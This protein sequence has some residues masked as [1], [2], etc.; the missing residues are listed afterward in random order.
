MA[1]ILTDVQEVTPAWLNDCLAR[2]LN[3]GPNRVVEIHVI[4]TR[5]TRISS[6]YFLHIIYATPD[7]A[8]PD[9]FFLKLPV[10]GQSLDREEIEFYNVLVP[11][12]A[13]AF[14]G[15]I[16]PFVACF[17]AAYSASPE[18][19]H[20]LLADMSTTHFTNQA[21]LPPSR[22]LCDGVI[23]AYARFHAFW[24]GHPGLGKQ[25]GRLLTDAAVDNF[26]QIAQAKLLALREV[27]GDAMT[28]HQLATLAAVAGGWPTRRRA[29]VVAG[30]GITIVH[31]DPHP[32][33]FLYPADPAVD[34]VKLIDWQSWRVDTGT[35]DL[36]YM[37]AC[38][39][40]L[41]EHDGLEQAMLVR[42]LHGLEA[43]G[44]GDYRWDDL[45]YDYRASI[46]RCLFF[47]LISWSPAKWTEGI[48]WRERVARGLDA[49]ARFDCGELLV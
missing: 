16:S 8:L 42:Y 29:R 3:L 39:W 18:G 46:I 15:A 21:Q 2:T 44:V 31:R 43:A 20:L 27:V 40:P 19:S 38:H 13:N 24:W 17:D 47:L 32:L 5:K 14:S 45:I 48:G 35:D 41:S 1:T 6:A 26:I 22:E 37:M 25:V 34:G 28:A 36:A 12:M 4:N 23:D 9:R 30:K 7:A 11:Q 49:F 10:P 33:N